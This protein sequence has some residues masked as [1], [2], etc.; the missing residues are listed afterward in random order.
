[1]LKRASLAFEDASAALYEQPGTIEI[2]ATANGPE[3]KTRI[4]GDRSAG[5]KHMEIWCFDFTMTAEASRNHGGPGFLF[6]DSQLF[7][8]VDER[9]RARALAYGSHVATRLG[10]QYIVTLNS[11]DLPRSS[12]TGISLDEFVLPVR[13]TDATESGGLFG[14]RFD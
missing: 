4:Q 6:H 9:Q 10:I 11:D 3:F 5:V 13:L 14:F 2:R 7:D 1:V 12:E 8:G